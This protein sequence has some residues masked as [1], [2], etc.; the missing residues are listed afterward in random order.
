LSPNKS[1]SWLR[2]D[3]DPPFQAGF[4]FS[5]IDSSQIATLAAFGPREAGEVNERSLSAAPPSLSQ[6]AGDVARVCKTYPFQTS[7]SDKLLHL[8]CD[9]YS[10]LLSGPP[11]WPPARAFLG[12][13]FG[14]MRDLTLASL[15]STSPPVTLRL[16]VSGSL[17]LGLDHRIEGLDLGSTDALGIEVSSKGFNLAL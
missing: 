16:Q 2:P 10:S 12:L 9:T 3:D 1:L 14:Q 7:Q 13:L 11:K 15:Q 4:S 6:T 8:V 5:G 17:A